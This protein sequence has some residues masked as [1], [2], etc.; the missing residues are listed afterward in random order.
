MR[1]TVVD[2]LNRC[3]YSSIA[4]VLSLGTEPGDLP[5]QIR[6]GCLLVAST[7]GG[8]GSDPGLTLST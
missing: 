2:Q 4:A 3:A 7:R 6:A 5:A 8:Q 1:E